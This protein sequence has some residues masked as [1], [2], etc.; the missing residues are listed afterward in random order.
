MKI[1]VTGGAGYIGS[2]TVRELIKQNYEVVVIDNLTSGHQK[3]L[4]QE[5]PLVINDIG[6]S[7]ALEDIFLNNKIDAVIHFAGLIQMGES[8]KNPSLYYKNNVFN[9]LN[10]FDSMVKYNV[11]K[12]V[13]S[14]S[15]GVY[16]NPQTIPIPEDIQ[17]EPTNPYGE[18]K[19]TIEKILHWYDIAYNLKSISIRYFNAAGAS[20][21]G[22]VGEA[23]KDESHI[24]PN[25]IKVALGQKEKFEIFGKDYNTLDG[26]CVRDYIHVLDLANSHILAIKSLL[27]GADSNCFNA[28]TGKGYSNLQII[29]MVKKVSGV[30]FKADFLEKRA[31][32]AGTLIADSSKIKKELSFETKYSDIETIIKSAWS[33][34]RS[35]PNG[36]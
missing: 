2:I 31:G 19:L 27:S 22:E 23:H 9:S 8:V 7:R 35:H 33:W 15:A 17:K 32:D 6:N 16:G 36:Y 29:E 25:A 1:L 21:D 26:T 5:V 24:I 30:N 13:F 18:T 20:L 12:I 28:G 4:P 3:A 10:L 34:H 11:L 14:S